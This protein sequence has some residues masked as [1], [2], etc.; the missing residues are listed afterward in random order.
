MSNLIDI[1]SSEPAAV[2]L[3][4]DERRLLIEWNDTATD[5]PAHRTI[6]ELFEEWAE[7]T[8]D[9]VAAILGEQQLTY[10]EI[11]ERSNRLARFLV[12]LGVQRD[13]LVGLFVERSLEMVVALLG[14]LKA[15]GA[16]LPID[17]S[18]P[19]A[20]IRYILDDTGSTVLLTQRSLAE[21]LA[22]LDHPVRTV[23][24]EELDLTACSDT[25]PGIAVS[26][27]NL[28]YV[29]YTSGSTGGPK[30]VAV[31]HSA[32]SRLVRNTN[33]TRLDS[34]KCLLSAAPVAFDAS[35]FELWGALLNGGRVVLMAER[36]P[37]PEAIAAL[38]DRHSIDTAWLTSSL[39]NSILDVAPESLAKIRQLL[40]GGE[41][42][43]IRHI[44][45]AGRLL[46]GT[47]LVNGY[48]PTESTTFTCTYPIPRDFDDAV[49]ASVPIG[50]PIANTRV[51]ILDEALEPVAVGV[52]GELFIGGAGLARGYLNR[53]ALTAEKFVPS[54][55]GDSGSRLYRT[56]DLVRY[57]P[58]G[59]IEFLGRA[60]DQVK[61]RGFRIELG[62]IE[63][64]LT[65]H[66][67]VH[68]AVV[69]AR[70]DVPGARRLVAY[71]VA[72]RGESVSGRELRSA[73]G[74][75][76]PE[77]MLPSQFVFM[78]AFPLS[79]TGKTDRRALPAPSEGEPHVAPCGALEQ[80]LATACAGVLGV[81]SVSLAAS[82]MELGGSSLNASRVIAALRGLFPREVPMHLLLGPSTLREIAAAME[83]DTL[84][85]DGEVATF[86]RAPRDHGPLPA[87]YSQERVWFIHRMD[88]ASLAYQFTATITLTGTLDVAA[89]QTALG[90]IVERHEIYRTTFEDIDGQL[91][92]VIHDPWPVSLEVA[93]AGEQTVERIVK[94]EL[95][96]PFDL[97]S[98]PLVRW[99]LYRFAPERHLLVIVEHHIIH[100]GWSFNLF[101]KELTE[102]YRSLTEGTVARIHPDPLQFADFA[103]WQ[104]RWMETAEAR[105][106][107]DFW[108]ETLAG[109]PPLLS[110]PYDRKRP[111]VQSYNGACPRFEIEPELLEELTALARQSQTTLFMLFAAA[112]Q[113][114]MFEAS[115]QEELC[116][117]TGIA[118][119]RWSET[120]DLMGMLV[121]NIGL[122]LRS[123]RDMSVAE[124]IDRVKR[125]ALDA[126]AR[127]DVPFDQVVQAVR[128]IRDLSHNP[129][130]QVMLSFHDSP[131]ECP[132][133]SSLCMEVE[134]GLSNGAAKFDLN[135]VVAAPQQH[136][137]PPGYQA[138][139]KILWEYNTDLFDASTMESMVGRYLQLLQQL[140]SV[141]PA[142]RISELSDTERIPIVPVSNAGRR[143][144]RSHE[145]GERVEIEGR[146]ADLSA[147]EAAIVEH[148]GV[149]ACA[150]LVREDGAGSKCLIACFQPVGD[151]PTT[152]ELRTFLSQRIAAAD[153]PGA[154]VPLSTLALTSRGT[155]DRDALS[156]LDL[157][158][159]GLTG[160]LA[161]PGT[162][163]EEIVAAI[164]C[165]VLKI[166]RIWR[167][168]NFFELGGHS[169]LAMQVISRIRTALSVEVPARA[170]FEAPSIAR[171]AQRV[172][173]EVRRSAG[174]R[175]PAL[176]P[177]AS[178]GPHPLSF[179][180]QRLWFLQQLEPDSYHYNIRVHLR[181]H[182]PLDETALADALDEIVR[183]HD[184]LRSTFTIAGE[185]P[186]QVVN[187]HTSGLLSTVSLRDVP[188][189]LREQQLQRLVAEHARQPFDLSRG[190]LLRAVLARLTEE[191]HA[192]ILTMHHVVSDGWS[193]EL[194]AGE[195]AA[196][197]EAYGNGATS[198]L[199]ELPVQYA[200]YAVWQQEWMRG[201]LLERQL[202]YWKEQLAAVPVL[203]L[204]LV[205]PRP[206]VQ[207][208]AGT[209]L[210]FEIPASV[211][212]ALAE[213]SRQEGV[214]LFMTLLAAF[215]I[216]LHRYSGQED[217]A[218][219]TPIAG[220][221]AKETEGLIGFFVNTLTMRSDLSGQPTVRELL[222][223]VREMA[224]EAYGHQDVPFER[225]VDE[226]QPERDMSR[227]PLFQVM[228]AL[229]NTPEAEWALGGLA[230]KKERVGT[231]SEKFDLTLVLEQTGQA[232]RGAIGYQ[233]ALFDAAMIERMIR[234]FQRLLEGMAAD[235]EAKID[236]LPLLLDEEQRLVVERW[237]ATERHYQTDTTIA[238]AF[239]AQVERTPDAVAVVYESQTL[240]YRELNRKA[241][242]LAGYLR[243]LG[244]GTETTVGLSLE[245]GL[246]MMVGL[247]GILKAGGA[248]VPLDPHYPLERMRQMIEDAGIG[249]VLAE[250]EICSALAGSGL[251][252]INLSEAWPAIGEQSEAN[253]ESVAGPDNLA[254]VIFTSG[255]TG[256]P[257]GVAITHRSVMNLEQALREQ[258]RTAHAPAG[259]RVGVNAPIVFDASVK[260]LVQLLNGAALVIV[261]EEVRQSGKRF[262]SFIEEHALGLIDCTPS[263]LQ[264]LIDQGLLQMVNLSTTFLIGGEA[265]GEALWRR[266]CE[267]DTQRAGG[268]ERE[269]HRFYNVYGPTECTVD[270]AL[271][272]IA[273]ETA[274][275]IGNAL[276]N[277]RLYVLDRAMQA[278][279]VG[280]CGELYV[281]G[282]GLA[283][284]YLGRPELTAERFVPS[285]FSSAGGERLYR[286]GDAVRWRADGQLEF[287]GRVDQ[288]VKI[289]GFRIELGEIETVLAAHPDVAQAVVLVREEQ[290]GEKRLV[291]YL[292]G[293]EGRGVLDLE[294]VR[295]HL[296]GSL[297]EYMLPGGYAVIE[298]LPLTINGKVDRRKLLALEPARSE[299]AAGHVAARTPLEELLAE[300]W[301]DVLGVERI[302][303]HDNFFE[304]GGHSLL[305]M[306]LVSRIAGILQVE[307]PLR[308]IFT[309]P[310]V[311]E[312]TEYITLNHPAP[313]QLQ[314]IADVY[315]S[316]QET[317]AEELELAE[318]GVTND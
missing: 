306:Q 266:L 38:A 151:A 304:A 259:R 59:N 84:P 251:Q 253:L 10:R 163:T 22:G 317:D 43:S 104:R 168:D 9:A 131:I 157:D 252:A 256:R 123:S 70:Q 200:D 76:L 274:P 310:T 265:I 21:R 236:E 95:E 305:A 196:L 202:S 73:L 105:R 33:F 62:E 291:A 184:V 34:S 111:A 112:F 118:N 281:G 254:Y 122:R 225:L 53:P 166:E 5:F 54:P 308:T 83:S 121:N 219:G 189:A 234:H 217:V 64:E 247:V 48:G 315:K 273:G 237:N 231:E 69:L 203:E 165:R 136:N 31:P 161:L 108:S 175:I 49:T 172:D 207:S 206:A 50:R 193:M 47:T 174:G 30:G 126:Y 195:L 235:P 178:A 220:R 18:Y 45:L 243:T 300:I 288:Q 58:D 61:I 213:L 187:R 171:F 29:I 199:P 8:P 100:D 313:A 205:H 106:Q 277:A 307:V 41:A 99:S 37:T 153:V 140:A 299:P 182:G 143:Q 177:A 78:S 272:A 226:L 158:F 4:A 148:P 68:Q 280:V 287:V 216:L 71:V 110:L 81:P 144:H 215:N 169:L 75:R 269:W 141:D 260:Q 262:L 27:Q 77:Y 194:F 160:D 92:Q 292:V 28:A 156:G 258:I 183:R 261:P 125:T 102:L 17:P 301:G 303:I 145:M 115:G 271:T 19:D 316:L 25:A 134:P 309:A 146:L 242:Q 218:V 296:K 167:F 82:F 208:H 162:V 128:P 210:P 12:D 180:Q 239:E 55:F 279:P 16:Y 35:T 107:L 88:P 63:T 240:S 101:Q 119:R 56:G 229:Q 241:N 149:A 94:R 40:V 32:V 96:K 264:V 249:I 51:Y 312:L 26:S 3:C 270:S 276:H 13:Q 284:G 6:H 103:K 52:A 15:G 65:Q 286:T 116:I 120:S 42:L 176:L 224:L 98:L 113:I 23:V 90:R 57:Q 318:E 152:T 11:S 135:I 117:G 221:N 278:V 227:T 170:L 66:P 60:D 283:R 46:T 7:Q 173:E 228:F 275:A 91:F 86:E 190:P 142:T 223:R 290:P 181:L 89:L 232:L 311:A 155:V 298:R 150:V 214:T 192:L 114:L 263:H 147:I 85:A 138:K 246:A 197:Y 267:A 211:A 127:Q 295:D 24:L 67:A 212:K 1:G 201:E 14:I 36:V 164:W 244:V 139:A 93:D 191:E 87:S 109:V 44:A 248:Y 238:A 293:E 124:V 132:S 2:E 198:P 72:R 297:P 245:R 302:G 294:S 186:V 74:E 188:D 79:A 130:F 133:L 159:G 39:F 250:P 222:A 97:A 314:R 257:K 282:A 285:P 129:I 137:L 209:R 204:P 80:A 289:R 233:T 179:A 268:A 154:F 230:V 255:S 20:R 185:R